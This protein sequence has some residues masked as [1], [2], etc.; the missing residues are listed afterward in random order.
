MLRVGPIQVSGP[1]M[2]EKS[3]TDMS[4]SQTSPLKAITTSLFGKS[5]YRFALFNNELMHDSRNGNVTTIGG[6]SASSPTVAAIFALVND[7]L[8]AAG[9]PQLGFVNPWLYR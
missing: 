5:F 9:K 3:Y 4:I 7:A 2:P 8:L 1:S 6:T